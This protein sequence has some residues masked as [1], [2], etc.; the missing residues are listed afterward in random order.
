MRKFFSE[1]TS[2]KETKLH[3]AASGE[4]EALQFSFLVFSV[5]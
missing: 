3:I 5:W 2:C 4:R 1:S